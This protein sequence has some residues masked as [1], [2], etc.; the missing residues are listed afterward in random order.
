MVAFYE[1]CLTDI[2]PCLINRQKFIQ[3]TLSAIVIEAHKSYDQHPQLNYLNFSVE[4][5]VLS[6]TQ[7]SSIVRIC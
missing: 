7:T 4:Y 3:L 2:T 5:L 6:H 1:K